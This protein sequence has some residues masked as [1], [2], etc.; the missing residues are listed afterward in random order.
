LKQNIS[1][2]CSLIICMYSQTT[3][4]KSRDVNETH[5][6]MQKKSLWLVLAH[7]L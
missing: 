6:K 5:A 2:K 3:I 7:L 4:K 1:Q